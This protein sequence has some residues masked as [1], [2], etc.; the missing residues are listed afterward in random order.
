MLYQRLPVEV[1]VLRAVADRAAHGRAR[2]G[3]V[4]LVLPAHR[5]RREMPVVPAGDARAVRVALLMTGHAVERGNAVAF[6]AAHDVRE[7]AV[8]VV[9]L[10]R[11]VRRRVA[12]DAARVREHRIDLP[13]RG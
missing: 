3:L 5:E 11:V 7:V 2:K 12:V 1:A 9:A 4:V 8:A 13:P 6:A 10:L